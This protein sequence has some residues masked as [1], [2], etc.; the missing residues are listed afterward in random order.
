MFTGI[1]EY[2]VKVREL[3]KNR[4]EALLSLEN[5]FSVDAIKKGDSIAVDGV[6]LT[7]TDFSR[8]ALEFFVSE[9]TLK[10]SIAGSYKKDSLVNLERA[11]I[12]GGRLDGH[13]VTGHVDT[14][15]FIRNIKKLAQGIEIVVEIENKFSNL[16]VDRGSVALNGVSLTISE[17]S[18]N[19]FTISLIPETMKRTSFDSLLKIGAELNVEFDIL[20]KYVLRQTMAASPDFS[21]I[22]KK[23]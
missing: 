17:C 20:G 9:A 10:K 19:S 4:G 2:S 18:K 8:T 23:L 14:S 12:L 21:T 5:P 1:I 13:I 15:G 3:K 16:I 7:V 22:L 6:C 11:M